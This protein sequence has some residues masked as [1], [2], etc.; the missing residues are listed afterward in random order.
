MSQPLYFLRNI[1]HDGANG[2]A[3]GGH[4]NR[5]L[6]EEF[7]IADT[8]RDCEGVGIDCGACPTNGGDDV[9]GWSGIILFYQ[10]PD[11][12]KLPSHTGYG[13][14]NIQW[15]KMSEKLFIGIDKDDPPKPHEMARKKQFS[16]YFHE[17]WM[18][19]IIRRP[20]DTTEL[21][22]SFRFY[23]VGRKE[24]IH[25]KY[26]DV[27]DRFGK[28][29]DWFVNNKFNTDEFDKWEAVE[30]AIAAIGVNY[31]FS[32]LEQTVLDIVTTEDF[33]TLL[34]MAIDFFAYVRKNKIQL[35]KA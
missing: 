9:E 30:M 16:G 18:I 10:Q 17:E 29:A 33:A 20:D 19:P 28:V 13:R 5:D 21:P 14:G 11:G 12:L 15:T 1:Q 3:P 35:A 25:D 34:G 8:F 2:I 4:F 6:L 32:K 23:N 22:C 27:Y 26:R 7:G 24:V 31:R